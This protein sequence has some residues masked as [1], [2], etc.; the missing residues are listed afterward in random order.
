M[1]R[2]LRPLAS[3]I[4]WHRRV[5]GAAL[6]AIAVLLL[7]V[8]L[9]SPA[10]STA[11]VILTR[12]RPAGYTLSAADLTVRDLPDTA[13]PA[14]TVDSPTELVGRTLVAGLSEGSIVQ[15]SLLAADHST[16]QGRAVVPIGISDEALRSLLSPGDLVS[17]VAQGPEEPLVVSRD[18][19]IVALA[20]EPDA[21][22]QLGSAT[23]RRSA[24][25]LVEVAA[26][27]AATVASLGQGGG[28]S[29]VLGAV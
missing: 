14:S 16:R 20:P 27:D 10:P 6:A 29:L 28:L 26:A 8:T 17:L 1:R 11:V 15:P 2:L 4:S 19:R 18:A 7:A 3:F 9:R 25:I 24:M 23:G 13:L 5:V 21:T 22:T 12:D